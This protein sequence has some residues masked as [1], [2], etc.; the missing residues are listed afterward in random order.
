MTKEPHLTRA[1]GEVVASYSRWNRFQ[2]DLA[3]SLPII[4]DKLAVRLSG[5]IEQSSGGWQYSLAD[6]K[7]H[8][9]LD[10]YA[11]RGQILAKPTENFD[12][13]VIIDGGANNNEIVMPR[14]TGVYAP[15]GGFCQAVLQGRNDDA[16]CLTYSQLVT[17]VGPSA[18]AQSRGGR[19]V[20]ADAFGRND[21]DTI[22]VTTIANLDLG[23]VTL[24]SVTGYRDFD[25]RQAQESDGIAGEWGHQLSGSFFKSW[26]QEL[27]LRS[28]GDGPLTWVA[29]VNWA[30]DT[31]RERRAFPARDN[32]GFAFLGSPLIFKLQ[33][34]QKS[35][36]WATFGQ[37]DYAL[38]DTVSVSGALRYTDEK[39]S[40]DDG[41]I[42]VA[43][44]N[45][46]PQP[47]SA[48]YKLKA[49][50]SGK[51][52]VSWK[53]REELLLY[54]SISRG[55]KVG[56]FFG[57]FAFTG[58]AG[59]SPYK[60][61]TVWAYEIGSK[62]SFLDGRAGANLALYYY[63][64]SD[65]QSFGT[66]P[67]PVVGTTTRL[68]NVGDAKHYGV[69]L[70]GFVEPLD[71]L[72]IAGSVSYLDAKIGNS[73]IPF[74]SQAGE[75]LSYNGFRRLYAPKWSW[76]AQASYELSLG[77]A[78]ALRFQADANG[79]STIIDAAPLA[80]GNG[81]SL[82][83]RAIQRTPG[84][85]V[86]NGRVTYRPDGGR[87]DV[88][89]FGRNLLNEQ[90]RTVWGGDGLG[91]YWRIYGEPVSYGVEFSVRW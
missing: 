8:G 32:L 4:T 57:G 51:A 82:V 6:N 23:G 81:V 72:R 41:M 69:E 24:T 87:W 53:L 54:A 5:R 76:T 52:N 46:F 84:Y 77:N 70:D 80:N 13:R 39:K 33:Y 35:E 85:T 12:I 42:V 73:S 47:L 61:E 43:G 17:G 16:N 9:A 1:T 58:T 89:I 30:K 71:G 90:Y 78:G 63:D 27:R 10:A 62:N 49:H 7:R 74:T 38:S 21:N 22:G 86:V 37:V 79:R 67:D 56:G 64:Y 18:S 44:N 36:S 83:D 29:G 28:N 25:F 65:V 3:A 68:G 19:R 31:L 88:S 20:L 40:Y 50:W 66:F 48:E 59:I 60:E 45:F 26:S 34:N 11:L 15:G 91:S 75:P 14:A 55:F 2:A